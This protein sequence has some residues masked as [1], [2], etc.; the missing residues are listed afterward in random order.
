VIS[1]NWTIS[2]ELALSSVASLRRRKEKG[3]KE[4]NLTR[5]PLLRTEA[6]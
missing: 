1:F 6:R 2:G 3:G 4:K 5:C